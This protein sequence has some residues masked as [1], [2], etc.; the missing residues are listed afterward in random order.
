MARQQASDLSERQLEKLM[1][2]AQA[3]V[4]QDFSARDHLPDHI[5]KYVQPVATSTCQGLYS[6]TMMLLG[7]MAALTNGASV[8]IWNQKPS[9]LASLVFQLGTPQQGK[10][11]LFAAYG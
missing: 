8:R 3:A 9:P 2:L 1:S 7:S 4:D 11:R 5:Y 6:T 10:S